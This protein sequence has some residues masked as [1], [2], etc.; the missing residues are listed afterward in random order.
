MQ[1]PA[2]R[3]RP[4]GGQALLAR[5]GRPDA[6]APLVRAP[7][8]AYRG[9]PRRSRGTAA[10]PAARVHGVGCAAGPP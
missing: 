3:R 2:A 4:R 1:P 6:A 10:P 5:G 7:A 8:P 9:G